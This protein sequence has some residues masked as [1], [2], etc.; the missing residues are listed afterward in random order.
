MKSNIY[1]KTIILPFKEMKMKFLYARVSS[2]DGSQKIA[3]QVI[4]AGKYDEVFAKFGKKC[5][6]CVTIEMNNQLFHILTEISYETF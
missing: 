2:A 5:Q 3:R 4:E 6:L 1:S